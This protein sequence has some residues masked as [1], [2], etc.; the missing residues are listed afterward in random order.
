VVPLS[1]LCPGWLVAQR[2]Q[3]AYLCLDHRLDSEMEGDASRAS[4]L[5]MEPSLQPTL[6]AFSSRGRADDGVRRTSSVCL[7]MTLEV[8]SYRSSR[9][10]P[11]HRGV[12]WSRSMVSAALTGS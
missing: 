10:P 7:S 3:N 1:M 11:F 12:E 6:V 8:I 4:L 9:S 5:E 2:Y